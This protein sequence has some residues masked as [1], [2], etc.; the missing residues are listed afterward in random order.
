MTD[1]EMAL[2]EIW[3]ESLDVEKIGVD[4]DFLD[5]GGTSLKAFSLLVKIEQRFP[6]TP[7]IGIGFEA[8]TIRR[9]AAIL[10]GAR[11]P[12]QNARARPLLL[13]GQESDGDRRPLFLVHG[14]APDE[15]D[16]YVH[17]VRNLPDEMRV[18]GLPSNG[19]LTGSEFETIEEMAK[20]HVESI[21]PVQP[22]GPYRLAGYCFGGLLAFEIAQQ[23]LAVGE[24]VESLIVFHHPMKPL[25]T[26]RFPRTMRQFRALL[27]NSR[28]A[29]RDLIRSQT[30]FKGCVAEVGAWLNRTMIMR[31][32][33]RMNEAPQTG[34]WHCGPLSPQEH[35][36]SLAQYRALK[37]YQPRQYS[38]AVTLFRHRR[39]PIMQ[40]YDECM[41]WS[42]TCSSE[43][44]VKIVDGS[45]MQG[46]MLRAESAPIVAHELVKAL[47]AYLPEES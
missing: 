19:K 21:R 9:Q 44:T 8:N 17:L 33:D 10:D 39:L 11:T 47:P 12:P 23:L 3:R 13:K 4:D 28:L 35:E 43:I 22:I 26:F 27:S 37:K 15:L 6:K 40:P 20:Q 36:R 16:C 41:G 30:S 18:Y 42:E 31:S 25:E 1:T 46:S 45:S 29:I 34:F 5:S 14:A 7:G 2:M 24:T 38:G 32:E